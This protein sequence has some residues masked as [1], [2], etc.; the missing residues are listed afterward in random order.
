MWTAKGIIRD[1]FAIAIRGGAGESVIETVRKMDESMGMSRYSIEIQKEAG[2]PYALSPNVPLFLE[3]SAERNLGQ[4]VEFDC[5]QDDTAGCV[6]V[7]IRPLS[8]APDL[9]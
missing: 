4:E 9:V 8:P 6:A 5:V 2:D 7:K 1:K 3:K